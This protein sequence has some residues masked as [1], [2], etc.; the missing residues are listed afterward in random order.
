MTNIDKNP[1]LIPKGIYCY[2]DKGVC[3]YWDLIEEKPDQENGFCNYLN[4]GDGDEGILLLWDQV[5]ECGINDEI[6]DENLT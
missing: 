4:L 3:P 1:D 6:S 5:K 2:D